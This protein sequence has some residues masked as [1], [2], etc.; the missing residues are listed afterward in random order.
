MCIIAIKPA[1]VGLPALGVFETCF[2]NH[3]HGAG[4]MYVQDGK[5]HVRKGFLDIFEFVN[6]VREIETHM[7][8]VLH[9]RYASRGPVIPSLCH[10]FPLSKKHLRNTEVECDAAVVHNGTIEISEGARKAI[11]WRLR[12]RCSLTSLSERTWIMT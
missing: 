11:H 10:P 7:A 4:F 1:G 3:P 6:A 9:F 8:A 5:V 2:W 12:A